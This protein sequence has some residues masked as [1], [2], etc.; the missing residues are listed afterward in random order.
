[1]CIL[2]LREGHPAASCPRRT[3][4][5]CKICRHGQHNRA[6]CMVAVD[7]RQRIV[8]HPSQVRAT[9]G[10][11]IDPEASDQQ[12]HSRTTAP[13]GSIS[14]TAEQSVNRDDTSTVP[15]ATSLRL[16][17][18]QSSLGHIQGNLMNRKKRPKDLGTDPHGRTGTN[19]PPTTSTDES[20][21]QNGADAYGSDRLLPGR[22]DLLRTDKCSNQREMLQL[23]RTHIDGPAGAEY[24]YELYDNEDASHPPSEGLRTDAALKPSSDA[25]DET[26]FPPYEESTAYVACASDSDEQPAVLHEC[27]AVAAMNPFSMKS[28]RAVIMFDSGSTYSQVSSKLAQFLD[29]PRQE[30]RLQHLS[31]FGSETPLAFHGFRTFLVLPHR[32]FGPNSAGARRRSPRPAKG[33]CVPTPTREMPDLLI[34]QDLVHLFDRQLD[35]TLPCGFYVV[36]T[37]L[38]PTV[39]GAS[40]NVTPPPKAPSSSPPTALPAAED[41]DI[42]DYLPRLSPSSPPSKIEPPNSRLHLRLPEFSAYRL[43]H[44]ADGTAESPP[45]SLAYCLAHTADNTATCDTNECL[46]SSTSTS[47]ASCQPSQLARVLAALPP[48]SQKQPSTNPLDAKPLLLRTPST[49]DVEVEE[50]PLANNT[51][52]H[53]R[54]IQQPLSS[55][56]AE[57]RCSSPPML[58][59]GNLIRASLNDAGSDLTR[60][61]RL[62]CSLPTRAGQTLGI[63]A[64]RE[65]VAVTS[66]LPP[67]LTCLL[68]IRAEQEHQLVLMSFLPLQITILLRISFIQCHHASHRH[69]V[70]LR[71]ARA[72]VL[73][74]LFR[75]AVLYG[76]LS[77][78]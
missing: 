14:Q 40:L 41:T 65:P 71:N 78:T 17:G 34:G 70:L 56:E 30:T 60:K 26:R 12:R 75:A 74:S 43:A 8:R 47:F 5:P 73:S 7:A 39:G 63:Y 58:S 13:S 10:S 21:K 22:Y 27:L 20:M 18:T 15:T 3:T 19:R 31:I 23:G 35:P 1:M 24:Q 48:P 64:A 44:T 4:Y 69:T 67:R 32:L 25:P 9:K 50:I 38:G 66:L 51:A 57:L 16:L 53:P 2:C 49:T 6:L 36:R 33:D 72:A 62:R 37:S 77:N 59:Y 45:D 11:N 42:A 76:L 54:P 29:L 52:G 46:D 28:R 68:L 55:M 61:T